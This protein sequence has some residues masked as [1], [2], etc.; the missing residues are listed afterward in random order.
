MLKRDTQYLRH[1]AKQ[2]ARSDF[3]E[4]SLHDVWQDN[5]A[6]QRERIA[7]SQSSPLKSTARKRL[8]MNKSDRAQKRS[9]KRRTVMAA[10]WVK[11]PI[12]DEIDRMARDNG[13]TRS[14]TIAT[15][16]EEAVHQRLHVQHAVLLKPLIQQAIREELRKDRARFAALLVRNAF[17]SNTNRHLL[18]NILGRQPGM[19][20]EKLNKIRDWSTDKAEKASPPEP[21]RWTIS[22]RP[23]R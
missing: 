17:D 16:L 6:P 7:S 4:R 15:L 23:L 1:A 12:S 2:Q 14:K 13:L 22:S 5:N 19:T 3:K 21:R 10:G 20:P 8:L 11:Q 9:T 18:G